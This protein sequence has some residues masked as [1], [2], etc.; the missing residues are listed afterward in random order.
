MHTPI[1]VTA[2][3][4][5]YCP[6]CGNCDCPNVSSAPYWSRCPAADRVSRT[7]VKE[8]ATMNSYARR[9]ESDIRDA[10]RAE[11]IALTPSGEAVSANDAARLAELRAEDQRTPGEIADDAAAM[12]EIEAA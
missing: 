1:T 12:A 8:P 11:S 7:R 4:L 2:S 3:E 10:A 9:F 6:D 5:R